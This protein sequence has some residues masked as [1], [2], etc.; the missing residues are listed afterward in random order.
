MS[1]ALM[2]GVTGLQAHQRMLDVAGNNLANVNTIGYKSSR[3]IFSELLA[4][5]LKRASAPTST[6]GGSNPQ[7]IGSGVQVG[8]I[9]PDMAQGNLINT[10]NPLDLAIEGE[11][12]FV[13]SDGS[14]NV[15]TRAGAFTVDADSNLVDPSTGYIVQRIGT[16]GESEGFQTPGDTNT[17]V[18][19]DLAIPATATSEIK[20][21]G[22][23]SADSSLAAPQTNMM[24]SGTTYTS[25]GGNANSG[26]RISDLDQFSGAFGATD[27]DGKLYVSG[28][29]PDGTPITDT[30]GLDVDV[31]TTLNDVLTYIGTQLGA[32][33]VT[34]S[35]SNGRIVVTD[36]ASGYSQT[37]IS[38]S[39]TGS[40]DGTD[41]LTVPGYF[42]IATVGGDEV[43]N[44]SIV[45]YDSQ[46]GSH[47]LS[48]AF[49]RT[50]TINLW[51]MVLT[52]VSGDV[53]E[54]T[55]GNRRIEG[56]EFNGSDGS[57]AGLNSVIG[58]TAQFAVTFAHDPSNPQVIT[59]DMGTQGQYNGLTQFA[60]ESTAVAKEQDGY[61]PG[62]LSSVSVSNEGYVIG[63]FTNGAKMNL[64]TIQLAL[65]K[66]PS[67][68]E[69]VGNSYYIPSANSGDS[70]ATQGMIG[71]AGTIRGGSL[72]KS[73]ADVASQFVSMIQ[74]QN[75]YHANARTI[76]I[77]NEMLKELTNLIR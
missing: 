57:F 76:T 40:S 30:V 64:A 72:E 67:A 65:F 28:V 70:V 52:S 54:L 45:T 46:G 5:V 14:R 31:N 73:N 60:R 1:F 42:E 10:S 56:I 41:S 49:V 4:Q 69:S 24:R 17:K 63:S 21:S 11:G 19:Y 53:T 77:A 66:N 61:P 27:I 23:L 38:L 26:T 2:A 55:S 59:V 22:N 71:G 44:F 8:G 13:L 50:D 6:V 34:A 9:S 29:Q 43:K 32:A 47:A 15:Y 48:G 74:A 35:I 58:D 20:V 51:D 37:D 7:Q 62:D 3:I 36:N 39:Y 12:Y 18:P 33:N 68:L 75:G 16:V 25:S